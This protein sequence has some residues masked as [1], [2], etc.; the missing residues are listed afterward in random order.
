MT[1]NLYFNELLKKNKNNVQKAISEMATYVLDNYCLHVGDKKY[2]FTEIEFYYYAENH[3]DPFCK[4]NPLKPQ[5]TKCAEIDSNKLFF[6]YSGI[7]ISFDNTEKNKTKHQ[8]GGILIRGIKSQDRKVDISGPLKVLFYLLN[9]TQQSDG[10]SL[11]LCTE[12]SPFREENK[13]ISRY[14]LSAK[15]DKDKLKFITMPYRFHLKSAKG[16]KQVK[17]D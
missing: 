7:D 11:K 13:A 14:G 9:E 2:W 15:D 6:H 10:C 3:K 1:L 8:Y 16:I 17:I 5:D 12:V 4:R